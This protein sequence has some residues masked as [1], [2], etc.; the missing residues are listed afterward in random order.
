MIGGGLL[1]IEAAYGL[2]KGGAK[3]TLVHVMDRL[4]ERQLDRRAAAFLKRAIERKGIRVLLDAQTTR[5]RGRRTR[6]GSGLRGRVLLPVDLVVV[7]VGVKANVALAEGADLPVN[8]GIIVD[9]ALTTI[10]PFVH[11]IGECAEHRGAVHGLVE[12]AYDQARILA[13]RLGGERGAAYEGTAVATNLKVSGIP[14]FSA[15]DFLG[16]EGTDEIVLEDRGAGL[17]KKLVLKDDRLVGAVLVGEAA[18]GLWYRDLIRN[19]ADVSDIR[20]GL[21]FGREFCES[22]PVP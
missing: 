12:P 15:G 13:R 5:S 21:I 6:R 4:M 10:V 19:G 2:A 22:A 16:G 14:V 17:C 1:G 3:V 11:A 7:A 9:D 20:S 8:R 18:D